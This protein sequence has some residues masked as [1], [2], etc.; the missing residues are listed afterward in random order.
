MRYSGTV[1][2]LL[3]NLMEIWQMRLG[4]WEDGAMQKFKSTQPRFTSGRS[5]LYLFVDEPSSGKSPPSVIWGKPGNREFRDR[6]G[7]DQLS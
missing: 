3:A 1:Y 2:H 4:K 7:I 5:T 6:I